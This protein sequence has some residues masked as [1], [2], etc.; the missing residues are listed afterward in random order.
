[1]TDRIFLRWRLSLTVLFLGAE[2]LWLTQRPLEAASAVP[3]LLLAAAVLF[4]SGPKYRWLL[5]ILPALWLLV[6][7]VLRLSGLFAARAMTALHPALCGLAFLLAAAQIA[8]HGKPVLYQWSWPT[9]WLVGLGCLLALILGWPEI[10][11]LWFLLLAVLAEL[12][13]CAALIGLLR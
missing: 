11:D 7:C 8:R 9:A 12:A 10:D 1:M 4:P 13:R 6:C 5:T 2:L 3:T